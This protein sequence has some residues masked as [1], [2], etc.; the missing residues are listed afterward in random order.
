M[1]ARLSVVVVGFRGQITRRPGQERLGFCPPS[2]VLRRQKQKRP[3]LA[4]G[5]FAVSQDRSEVHSA[6]RRHGRGFLLLW[7]LGHHRLGGDE[8]TGN[9]G[10]S[11]ERMPH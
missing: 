10:R 7:K 3:E 5:P 6:A 11:L 2:S 1:Y 4:P 8:E 9:R